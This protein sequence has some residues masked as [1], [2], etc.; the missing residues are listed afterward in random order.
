MSVKNPETNIKVIDTPNTVT[1]GIDNAKGKNTVPYKI[2]RPF[3]SVG[4]K[5][6]N[7]IYFGINEGNKSYSEKQTILNLDFQVMNEKFDSTYGL[8]SF[9]L[10]GKEYSNLSSLSFLDEIFEVMDKSYKNYTNIN[11]VFKDLMSIGDGKYQ[12]S[13]AHANGF[14]HPDL[15]NDIGDAN[16]IR[17]YEHKS[18][19]VRVGYQITYDAVF[20]KKMVT[21]FGG[22]YQMPIVDKTNI[23][24]FTR[25]FC[26]I[27]QFTDIDLMKKIY[28]RSKVQRSK[29]INEDVD[30]F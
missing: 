19:I 15:P 28:S 13:V 26:A 25:S 27:L 11:D 16:F 17:M 2:K 22:D 21:V 7:D 20:R 14:S 8:W 24:A 12:S 10:V 3:D 9:T 5:G 29:N 1:I 23:V 30:K 4:R 18:K 6:F